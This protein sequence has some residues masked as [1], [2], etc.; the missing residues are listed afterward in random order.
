MN[1][2]CEIFNSLHLTVLR[3]LDDTKVIQ[4]WN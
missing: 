3:K 4:M 1:V 2:N